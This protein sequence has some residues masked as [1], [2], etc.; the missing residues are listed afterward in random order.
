MEEVR[1][2]IDEKEK[3]LQ[4]KRHNI[5]DNLWLF[6]FYSSIIYINTHRQE[7]EALGLSL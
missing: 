4:T 6:I 5:G 7:T 2:Y 3:M 1:E